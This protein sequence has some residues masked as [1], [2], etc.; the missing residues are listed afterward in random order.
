M[1]DI[2]DA[3]DG[4]MIARGD[5]GVEVPIERIA[6]IQKDLMRQANRCAKPVITATQMLESMTES[7]RPTRA[8]ATDVANAILDGTDCVMLSGESAMGKYPVDAVAMLARI[9]SVVEPHRCQETAKNLFEGIELKGR[10]KPRGLIAVAV[11]ASTKLT[12]PAA[13][14]V[15]THSGATAR[16][17]SLFRLPVWVAAVSSQPQTC[18]NLAFSYGVHPVHEPE[19]PD[20][21]DSFV[22]GWLAR[23][24]VPGDIAILTEGPSTKHPEAHNRMEIID[25]GH[26]RDR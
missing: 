8:E 17:L 23:H 5:L 12:S 6:V 19:H 16:A 2:L 9:A 4:I 21:W 26:R 3:A 25:L 15:P 10:L 20:D 18:Q 14:F 11:A 24:Q 7:R 1:D 22:R 13:V